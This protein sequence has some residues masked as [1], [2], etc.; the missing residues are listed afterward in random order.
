MS[1]KI[2][3]AD[4]AKLPHLPVPTLKETTELYLKT[5]EPLTTR[6]EYEASVK[7]VID[8]TKPGGVGEV[9][10]HRLLKR[11][12]EMNSK[13]RSWLIDWWNDYAYMGYR[14]PVVVF[15]SY[16]FGILNFIIILGFK[17]D[18]LRMNPALRAAS[19]VKGAL[20]FKKLI[21]SETLP[22]DMTKAGPLCSEQYRFLFNST[23]IPI[24]PSDVT[25]GGDYSNN[26][27]VVIRNN[28]FFV[29]DGRN[30]LSTSQLKR[31]Q[32]KIYI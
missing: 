13:G 4:Q 3:F 10:Q 31:Y 17:D 18:K 20:E 11:A 22:P 27:V 21:A 25:K 5:L 23:R 29:I 15:V 1:K 9:L 19:I 8:F 2:L 26:D 32:V 7:N 12:E 16:F 30:E 14:D 24:I 6:A 28:K